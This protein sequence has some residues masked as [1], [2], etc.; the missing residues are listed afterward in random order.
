MSDL[1]IYLENILLALQQDVAPAV[2]ADRARTSVKAISNVLARIIVNL[3]AL[4]SNPNVDATLDAP[5]AAFGGREAHAAVALKAAERQTRDGSV[6]SLRELVAWEIDILGPLQAASMD[7]IAG[8]MLTSPEEAP[9]V[10]NPSIAL[11]GYL[12][13]RFGAAASVTAF[14]DVFGGRSKMTSLVSIA[15]CPGLNGRFA[16]RRDSTVNLTGGRSVVDEYPIL[17]VLHA[18]GVRVPMPALMEADPAVMGTP[19]ILVERLNGAC[20]EIYRTPDSIALLKDVAAMLAQF[21]SVPLSAYTEAG[22][23]LPIL[24]RDAIAADIGAFERMWAE[25]G[26]PTS[27]AMPTAFRWLHGN[28]D[29]A[30]QGE[31]SL[32]HCDMRFHNILFEAD[33]VTGLLDWELARASYP[34]EDLGYIRPIV[35]RVMPWVDFMA[36]YTTAGG[37]PVAED[38]IDFYAIFCAA[39]FAALSASVKKIILSGDTRDMQLT[40]V[41]VHDIYIWVHEI[42][43]HLQRVGKYS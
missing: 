8:G 33:A 13:S 36:A 14:H 35:C 37:P 20:G 11:E 41:P 32:A 38:Q 10:E 4:D 26:G 43:E 19:F 29:R 42:G 3:R 30:F 40:A 17:Q 27:I 7:L 22:I 15:G 25:G 12:R 24:Q 6:A 34:A 21:H 31:R 2:T 16:M 18:R 5:E 9:T 28:L 23:R 39:R 1:G